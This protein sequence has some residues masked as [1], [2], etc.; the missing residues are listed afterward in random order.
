MWVA[1]V[2]I[3]LLQLIVLYFVNVACSEVQKCRG[4]DSNHIQES[5]QREC[6]P[7]LANPCCS[8]GQHA[9]M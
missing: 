8:F 5:N 1:L 6:Q 2:F 4:G 3:L 9:Y 7:A